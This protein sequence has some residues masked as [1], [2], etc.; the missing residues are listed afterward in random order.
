MGQRLMNEMK[1]GGITA[2]GFI[3]GALEP[4]SWAH[5]LLS[6]GALVNSVSL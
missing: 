1:P 4:V 2:S 5:R 3:T 6:L